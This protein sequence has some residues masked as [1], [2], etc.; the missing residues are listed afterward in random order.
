MIL[1]KDDKGKLIAEP[2]DYQRVGNQPF[3]I[4]ASAPCWQYK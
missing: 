3:L 4:L 2:Q 1:K